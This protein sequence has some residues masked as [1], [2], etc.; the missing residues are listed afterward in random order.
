MKLITNEI[1]LH[2]NYM[3]VRDSYMCHTHKN[4]RETQ[5]KGLNYVEP[6]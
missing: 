2:N 1:L 4:P 3:T 5:K 6:T